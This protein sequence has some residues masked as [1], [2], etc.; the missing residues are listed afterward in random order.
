MRGGSAPGGPTDVAVDIPA[1]GAG[2]GDGSLE[3]RH[4]GNLAAI[5]NDAADDEEQAV[6]SQIELGRTR[7]SRVRLD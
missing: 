3:T 5:T 4:A 7:I 2:F 1:V 6:S